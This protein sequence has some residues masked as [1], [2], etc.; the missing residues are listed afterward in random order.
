[1]YE[2]DHSNKLKKKSTADLHKIVK[3]RVLEKNACDSRLDELVDDLKGITQSYLSNNYSYKRV[4]YSSLFV[5]TSAISCLIFFAELSTFATFLSPINLLGLMGWGGQVAYF[6]NLFLSIYIAQM[7]VSSVF[8]VKVYKIF[9][10]HKKHSTASSLLFS[11]I[12]LS[13]ICYPLCFNYEQITNLPDSAFLGFFGEVNI[14]PRFAIV[15]P[16]LMLL[17]AFFNIFD[18]YDRVAGYLGLSSWAFDEEE[19][20]EK[21][22][23]GR[24]ILVE[25]FKER[26][27]Q[28]NQMEM[29]QLL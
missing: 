16:I 28:G 22:Q 8:R 9:A 23:E 11:A 19:A 6:L 1:M 27:S 26:N 3:K 13:R 29:I 4:L 21:K 7:V 2:C 18:F 20:Q 25:R 24:S 17:F 14:N 10:L 12:N 15:F 5:A